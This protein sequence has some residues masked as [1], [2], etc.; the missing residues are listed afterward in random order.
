MKVA[1]WHD[2]VTGSLRFRLTLTYVLFFS[3]LLVFL[4]VFF[5][6]T[7]SSVY[8]EQL[9]NILTE[10]WAAMRGYLRIEKPK[11]RSMPPV[12]HWFYD[13]DD[14]EEALIVDRL[15]QL[16]LLADANGTPIEVGPRY[17]LLPIETSEEIRRAV[18]ERRTYWE[19]KR[20]SSGSMYLIRSGVLIAED[21]KPYYVAIGRSYAEGQRI[22]E[23]FTLYYSWMLPLMIVSTAVLGW[24]MAG[25]A[26]RPVNEVANTAQRITGSTLA[27]RIPARGT[28]D[29]LDRFIEAFNRMTER[30]DQSFKQTR[31]FSTDVS[32]E[33]R[34]PLTAIRGQLEVALMAAKTPE[35]YQDA[36]ITA[37]EDVERLSQTIKSL[38]LLS[39]A[40]SGQVALQRQTID[41]GKIAA[42]IVDQ[43]GIPAESAHIALDLYGTG[44]LPIQADRIQIERLLSNLISNAI[45]YTKP[46]G[47]V[48]VAV[49]DLGEDAEIRI[50]DTGI[51]IPPDHLPYIFDRFYRVPDRDRTSSPERGL[52]LGLSFV[53]WIVK[54]HGGRIEVKSQ[55]GLGTQFCICLPK[56][57]PAPQPAVRPGVA[58]VNAGGSLR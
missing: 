21:D 5:R 35:Q 53:A 51:G 41:L 19:T 56:G 30:L 29:E 14:P 9:H 10:E 50:E 39:Q 20:D 57:T 13:R 12:V 15:R 52:G 32:H 16:Y 7:I 54:A 40:E 1:A 38:L 45:K 18:A 23:E 22:L 44:A 8:D 3:V 34:T 33:L 46:G 31:Q 36:I 49:S 17:R 37:L 58:N 2:R 27:T 47:R 11:R 55:A 6:Q 43:F 48:T 4:G 42:D 24:F 26:L 25:R 28:G